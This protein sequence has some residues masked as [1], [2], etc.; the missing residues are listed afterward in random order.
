MLVARAGTGMI[1]LFRVAEISPK[2]GTK[3]ISKKWQLLFLLF[4]PFYF[5]MGN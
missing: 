2:S 3:S 1:F 4:N 5:R